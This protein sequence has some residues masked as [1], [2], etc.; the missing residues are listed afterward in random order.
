[1]D[2]DVDVSRWVL[3]LLLRERNC[4]K[5]VLA[6]L[7]ISDDDGRLKKTLL[8]RAIE[9]EIL[10]GAAVTET[11]LDSLESIKVLDRGQGVPITDSMRAAYC[12]VATEMTVKFLV[13][14][15]GKEPGGKYV[16]AVDKIWRGRVRVLE[17][18]EG[19]G[20]VSAELKERRDEVE[21]GIRDIEVSKRL[22]SLDTR[23]D[24][25]RLVAAY[26]EEALALLGPP[27]IAWAV[28]Y[29][30]GKGFGGEQVAVENDGNVGKG[31][32]VPVR[33]ANGAEVAVPMANGVDLGVNGADNNS[34]AQMVNGANDVTNGSELGVP[35]TDVAKVSNVSEQE[36][37]D[38]TDK[39]E[40]EV[41]RTNEVNVSSISEQEA[42]D[43]N[44]GDESGSQV[45]TV[46]CFNSRSNM[47]PHMNG[48][49]VQVVGARRSPPNE[50]CGVL[51]FEPATKEK[52]TPRTTTVRRRHGPAKIRDDE[53]V[54][55]VASVG[56]YDS[57]SS[58]EIRKVQ[59]L[60]SDVGTEASVG[61]YN[62]VSSA[63]VRKVQ[64]ELKSGVLDL[65][66]VVTEPLPHVLHESEMVR[67]RLGMR[68][69]DHV[70]GE[71]K[72]AAN[73]SVEKNAEPDQFNDDNHGDQTS[74][75]NDVPQPIGKESCAPNLS[76]DKGKGTEN[77][78]TGDV[79]R[80]N[81]SCSSQNNVPRAGL[82]ERNSTSHT[83][84]W[85]DSL[86][87]SPE[88]T[89][90][91]GRFHLPSLKRNAFSPLKEYEGERF[92]KRRKNKRW[93]LQEEDM[94]RTCVQKYG[95]GRWKCILEAHRDV[96][97]DRTEV[98][99]KDKWRNMTK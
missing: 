5:R 30:L 54:S 17:E 33:V 67:S 29:S 3:E 26:V 2:S 94:L 69:V 68:P 47:D 50:N 22:A 36:A 99:L 90:S 31:C 76:V 28:R 86:G 8:L 32:E 21:A 39:S 93:S 95:I 58:A 43:T 56:I 7:P 92:P 41:P 27:F 38:A 98:D 96:F 91:K 37:H 88:L 42:R 87:M 66:A 11:I 23:N 57:V 12:A 15:G 14:S 62:S 75:Q 19:C 64:E 81:P 97:E 16:E 65:Q 78:Q 71:N 59:E 24:A 70:S 60:K 40:Q 13:C 46:S 6:V 61:I 74:H 53:D 73:P 51:S 34:E 1:M 84:E 49:Q 45:V 18:R 9:S 82:M 48:V 85:D 80:G 20:L 35:R 77:D 10:D 44:V 79:K 83:Y 72:S 4:D 89:Y 55:T 25:L 63:E 52:E